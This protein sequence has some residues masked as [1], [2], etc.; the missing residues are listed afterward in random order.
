M[1][2][3]E[4]LFRN[5]PIG[6]GGE[7]A[8]RLY[9][10]RDSKK[11]IRITA[12][13]SFDGVI[14]NNTGFGLARLARRNLG[15]RIGESLLEQEVTGLR[16]IRFG[17][18]PALYGS[19]LPRITLR[20]T[21]LLDTMK[22]G[23]GGTPT[24]GGLIGGRVSAARD[25]ISKKLGIPQTIIPTTVSVNDRLTKEGQTQNRMIDL[26]EI[27]KS[28]EGSIL[29]K[30]LKNG[31]G[32]SLQTIGRQAIGGLLSAAK[33]KIRGKLFG[34]RSTTGFNPA[35][36]SKSGS[37]TSFNYGSISDRTGATIK[38]DSKT[39]IRD[40]GGLKYSATFDLKIE[41]TEP[42]KV[43]FLNFDE[44]EGGIA[45]KTPGVVI[46]K[47]N[48]PAFDRFS[49]QDVEIPL[50]SELFSKLPLKTSEDA[51]SKDG[52]I[53]PPEDIT[54]AEVTQ[55][56][57]AG[58]D[59]S[60]LLGKNGYDKYSNKIELTLEQTPYSELFNR[61][62]PS[63]SNNTTGEDG[64]PT[65]REKLVFP[66]ITELKED[67]EDGSVLL[68]EKG[69]ETHS[70]KIELTIERIRAS[71]D[72]SRIPKFTAKARASSDGLSSSDLLTHAN[73]GFES[74]SDSMNEIGPYTGTKLIG[75][76]NIDDVDFVNLKFKSLT[77]PGTIANFRST[78]TGLTETFS[79]S[80][81]SAK[82]IG[83]AFNFYTYGGIERSVSFNFKVYSLSVREHIAAWQRLNFLT[84]LTY[85]GFTAANAI[86]APFMEITIGDMYKNK[87]GFIESLSYT[88]DDNTGWQ[89]NQ[90]NKNQKYVLSKNGET[91]TT[92]EE[93]TTNYVLPMV[94]DVA[95]TI[96]FVESKSTTS[97]KKFYNFQPVTS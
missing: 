26:A 83:S 23:T 19:E 55:L 30:F 28:G 57:D 81:D 8:E 78:I 82:F 69:Y 91:L 5:K 89:I 20:T 21:S 32:G 76:T 4:E 85:P 31:G 80:W 64:T 15:V 60:V 50:Y 93:D 45:N 42:G 48:I 65:N 41:D 7:T 47:F 54:F 61:L 36:P 46:R 66:K 25:A 33:D 37:N 62:D 18:I 74:N 75:T 90:T 79:P 94:V 3:L 59:N 43:N 2:T 53:L 6:P 22:G 73:R 17:S 35:D 9:D 63:T 87:P 67:G 84:G 88:I 38:T 44:L 40:V 1:P 51:I 68:G 10:I 56:K 92:A 27:R 16:V 58:E 70:D 77:S 29:G 49:A 52:K 13:N 96:K 97:G 14:I 72:P 12:S 86:I 24:S 34:E 11:E 95:I 71:S 39:G